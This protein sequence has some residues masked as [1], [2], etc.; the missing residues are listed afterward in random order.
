MRAVVER[1]PHRELELRRLLAADAGF[2]GICEDYVEAETALR[3]W[4]A[5]GETGV[6]V[7]SE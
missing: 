4:Q 2:R 1:F 5:L 7:A 3:R 6:G